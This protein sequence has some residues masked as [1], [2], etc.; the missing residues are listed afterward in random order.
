MR[1]RMKDQGLRISYLYS[2]VID[3]RREPAR[4]GAEAD[5]GGRG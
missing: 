3:R 1:L 5:L 4:V 2:N